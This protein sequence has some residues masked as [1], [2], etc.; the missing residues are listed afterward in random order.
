MFAGAFFVGCNINYDQISL[1]ASKQVVNLEVGETVDV[2]VTIE[3]YQAGFSNKV[4]LNPMAEGQTSIFTVLDPV[5][6]HENEFRLTIKGV[7]G[8]QGQLE[9]VTLEAEKRCVIDVSVSQNSSSMSFNSSLLYVSNKTTFVPDESLFVFDPHTTNTEVSYYFI[10]PGQDIN[11]ASANLQILDLE[12]NKATFVDGTG[13]SVTRNILQFDEVSLSEGVEASLLFENRGEVSEVDILGQFDMLAVYVPSLEQEKIINCVSTVSVFPNLD[14]KVTGGYVQSNGLVE[15]FKEITE[16]IKIVPNN[17]DLIEYML[18]VEM[19]DLE[20]A[21]DEKVKFSSIKTNVVQSNDYIAVNFDHNYSTDYD[22]GKNVRYIKITQNS[23][24]K[25]ETK[26]T[27]SL[28]YENAQKVEDESINVE[29]SYDIVTEIAPTTLQVNGTSEPEKLKL[30]NFY[31]SPEFGWRD[32]YIDVLSNFNTSPTFEGIY[33]EFDSNYLDLMYNGITIQSGQSRL[34]TDLSSPFQVRGKKGT[35]QVEETLLTIHLKSDILQSK[36][37]GIDGELT[38]DIPCQIIE[39]AKELRFAENFDGKTYFYLDYGSE[40]IGFSSQIY[41]DNEFQ[42]VNVKCISENDG[43]AIT[44]ADKPSISNENGRYYLNLSVTPLTTGI[45]TYILTLDNG[46]SQTVAFNVIK[47]LNLTSIPFYLTDEGNQNV[48]EVSYSKDGDA[49]F[50]NVMNI[51]ILNSSTKNY[52]EYGSTATF[53]IVANV[54][55]DGV[56]FEPNDSLNISVARSGNVYKITTKANGQTKI[57]FTLT[58][59]VVDELFERQSKSYELYVNASSYSLVDEFYFMN[60][61]SQALSNVVYYTNSGNIDKTDTEVQLTPIVNHESSNNFY[62]FQFNEEMAKYFFENKDFL[63]P[64]DEDDPLEEDFRFSVTSGNFNNFVTKNLVKMGYKDKDDSGETFGP[65]AIYFYALNDAGGLKAQTETVASITKT[66]V[67]SI[68]GKNKTERLNVSLGFYNGLM[69]NA[70]DFVYVDKNELGE[71]VATY[72]VTFDNIYKIGTYGEFD[73]N[74]FKYTNKITTNHTL[75][76]NANLSQRV[77]REVLISYNA[78]ISAVAYQSVKS[79]SLASGVD[80]ID[81]SSKNL[82]SLSKTIAVYTYPLA[83]TNNKI[84]VQ[85][86]PTSSSKLAKNMLEWSGDDEE[87]ESGVYKITLSCQKFYNTYGSELVNVDELLTGRIYI[88]PSEW[89]ASYTSIS[90]SYKPIVIDVQYRNG[91]KANPYI[92][93][94]AQ[95]VLDINS[96]ETSLKSHYEI[97]TTINMSSVSNQ[98]PIGVLF[99][100]GN[101]ELVGFSGSI[102]GTTAQARISNISISNNNF[103][104]RIDK[105]SSSYTYSGLFAQINPSAVIENVAFLGKFDGLKTSKTAVEGSVLTQNAY[106]GL[107]TSVNKGRLINVGTSINTS[108][109]S[110][111]GNKMYYGA[112]A[113][114][115][116]G[117][118]SQDLTKF[119]GTGYIHKQYTEGITPDD[120]LGYYV[121]VGD[122]TIR[123]DVDG[124]VV[125]NEGDKVKYDEDGNILPDSHDYTGQ[126]TRNLA[127]YDEKLTINVSN[128]TLYAGG[129][130]GASVGVVERILPNDS[131]FKMYGYSGYS[132]Y[133]DLVVA[134]DTSSSTQNI[135]VGGAIGLATYAK[136]V[137]PVLGTSELTG[138]DKNKID[139]VNEIINGQNG[140]FGLLVGGEIDTTAAA[141]YVDYVGGIAGAADTCNLG[142]IDVLSNISRTFLRVRQYVG[143]IV[144]L[145]NFSGA[146]N[147]SN[148]VNFGKSNKIQAVDDGR[149]SFYA[150]MIIKTISATLPPEVGEVPVQGDDETAED[151]AIRLTAYE[152]AE[153]ERNIFLAV[154][155]DNERIYS[156]ISF[157]VVSYL[158]RT[159]LEISAGGVRVYPASISS[160][161]D[162]YGDYLVASQG[163]GTDALSYMINGSAFFKQET[164]KLG[165]IESDFRMTSS[166]SG[167]PDLFFMYN[168]S[169]SGYLDVNVASDSTVLPQDKVDEINFFTPSSDLYPFTFESQEISISTS[170]SSILTVDVNGNM[171]TKGVGLATI[172]LSSILN[173]MESKTIYIYIFNYFDKNIT[174]SLFFTSSNGMGGNVVDGSGIT[175][176]GNSYT[177]LHLN[178]SYYLGKH[179][180]SDGKKYQI[181]SEGILNLQNVN[182]QLNK[183]SS[184]TIESS[185]DENNTFSNLEVQKQTAIFPKVDGATEF[186]TD[187]YSL[188]PVLKVSLIDGGKT[189]SYYYMF[190]KSQIN[191]NVDYRESASAIR[192]HY[193]YHSMKTNDSFSDTVT[194][195]S[196]NPEELLFYEIYDE[197]ENLVQSRLP[198]EIGQID[199]AGWENYVNQQND[200]TEK[201]IYGDLFGLQFVRRDGTNIFDFTCKINT[202]SEK[203]KNRFAENGNING[204]YVVK[205]YSSELNIGDAVCST[206]RI[207]LDEA[208]LNYLS[209]NN[210]SDFSK[211]VPDENN[212]VVASDKIAVPSQPGLLEISLDPVEAVF[213]TLTV[214]NNIINQMEGATNATFNFVYQRINAQNKLEFVEIST[215]GDMVTGENGLGDIASDGSFV[216]TYENMI[217]FLEENKVDGVLPYLGKVYIRYILPSRNVEDG[218]KVAFDVKVTHGNQGESEALTQTIPLTVKLGSYAELVFDSKQSYGG[219]YYVANGLSYDMTL[220]YYGFGLDQISFKV[221]NS[222]ANSSEFVSILP[223]GG[224]KFRLAVNLNDLSVPYN[225]DEPGYMVKITTI[226]EKIVD[227]I[228]VKTEDVMEIY[229]MEYVMDYGYAQGVNEDIVEGMENG[230]INNAIGSPYTL[231]LDILEFMEYDKTDESV[232]RELETFVSDMT[233]NVEWTVHMQK[234]TERLEEGKQIRDPDGEYFYINSFTVTPIKIYTPSNNIYHFSVNGYYTMGGGQYKYSS[235]AVNANQLYTEFSFDVHQQST[236]D[237]PI[238]VENYEELAAMDAGE[239]YILVK[240]IILP[241][242]NYA[243]ANE[244]SEFAPIAANFASLDGNGYKIYYSGSYNFDGLNAVGLFSSV[245]ENTVL[246]NITIQVI[247]DTTFNMNVSTFNVGLLAAENAGTI[248]N[249]LVEAV[250]KCGFSVISS[251]TNTAS[252]VAGLVADNSGYVT[253]SR[254]KVNLL[255]T[256]NLAGLVAQNSGLIA[257][258]YFM[259]G[260]L[261]NDT[262]SSPTGNYTAGLVINNSGKIYT[263]YVSGTSETGKVYYDGSGNNNENSITSSNPM[264]GFVFTNT[265]SVAD[266]YSNIRMD[267]NGTFNA[268]FVYE[269]SGTVERCFSTSVQ[270]RGSFSYGFVYINS[271]TEQEGD[272]SV[273]TEGGKIVDCFVLQQKEDKVNGIPAIND[274]VVL[275]ANDENISITPLSLSQFSDMSFF[276]NFVVAE[277]RDINSVWFFND[278]SD[279]V[280]N[281]NNQQFNTG[282]LELVAPNIIASSERKLDRTEIVEDKASGATYTRYIYVFKETSPALGS[283]YNPILIDS[284]ETFEDYI[285]QENNSANY[286]YSYYR[287]IGDIAY[288][289]DTSGDYLENGRTYKTKFMGYIEGNFMSIEGQ[290]LLSSASLKYA[291]MFAEL[292][293]SS[294]S[295]AVGTVMNLNIR[296]QTVSFANTNV[297]G[298]IAGK[299]D[300]G[301]I[302]NVTL[303]AYGSDAVTVDGNN[304]VGGAVGLALG[305]FRMENVHS[306]FS[307][308]ARNQIISNDNNF[309]SSSTNYALYSFAGTIA[310]VLSGSG[311]YENSTID[312][313]VSVTG[314]KAGL[315][316]G[317]I[318]EEVTARNL[319]VYIDSGMVVNG[320]NY[321]GFVAGESKGKISGVEVV[322][323]D[324]FTFTNI[325][326]I[327]YIPTAV[328][329]Y[330]GLVSGGKLDDIKMTQSISISTSSS[331]SGIESLGGI[332]GVVS[333][334]VEMSNIT[335]KANLTGFMYVGGVAGQID[336][337]RNVVSIEK[338]DVDAG[339]VVLGTKLSRVGIGGLAGKV[340]SETA[341]SMTADIDEI[342]AEVAIAQAKVETAQKELVDAET[343]EEGETRDEEQIEKLKEALEKA[344]EE[345]ADVQAEYKSLCNHFDVEMQTQL[346]VYNTEIEVYVGAILGDNQAISAHTV[347]D[348]ISNLVTSGHG[349]YV[350]DVNQP[351]SAVVSGTIS[352]AET[353]GLAISEKS[354]IDGEVLKATNLLSARCESGCNIVYTTTIVNNAGAAPKGN[355]LFLNIFGTLTSSSQS[356]A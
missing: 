7:A 349:I 220:D 256:V 234:M 183:N 329:G 27:L 11:F 248:T 155:R 253:H 16:N 217:K 80:T 350:E 330:A 269:N 162:F 316:F 131:T 353:G 66:Y 38:L 292:G 108:S 305:D 41:A 154:G 64:V 152:E 347:S 124:F 35:E 231:K 314:G 111:N 274:N 126:T 89:G 284:A 267:V 46:I 121:L 168:F 99:K 287:V 140:V 299:V 81:F 145:D 60:G 194:V 92:L 185:E 266:C 317:L 323:N 91:S 2:V 218:A 355:K 321:A 63:I 137:V 48:T 230:A 294:I 13:K 129:L 26:L 159:K 157:E 156:D 97:R 147:A 139:G 3:G 122:Q 161:T 303:E 23:Q 93:E 150:S 9:I 219:A 22:E 112:V 125:D 144:G 104:R 133:V 59:Y 116:Y 19:N 138:T 312:A 128:S 260:S 334:R 51:D 43:V 118:I 198:V 337:G 180:T 279:D 55:T 90:S 83:A 208:E 178:P 95:D 114:V 36:A 228:P 325:R 229:I 278:N 272:T 105:G 311:I 290:T 297:V 212:M 6:L 182:Y 74:N 244:C 164:V 57:K 171:T 263:S 186:L 232:A 304:I 117:K 71:V 193:S 25:A 85:Y 250:N 192:T 146:Y 324:D 65:K 225:P 24:K 196:T 333:A 163:L 54:N 78:R 302:I 243:D 285:V 239:H 143:G 53:E 17:N 261:T 76:L 275:L 213:D 237:S 342:L 341:I 207:R 246:K 206:F 62:R 184:I 40:T 135:F 336:I 191:I 255:A 39:G 84:T 177:T 172:K 289:G 107:L 82:S 96:G 211:V 127:F 240:D 75:I 222:T 68:T 102:I 224:G 30:Y 32:L 249:C 310:G 175:V 352:V 29:L 166:E 103:T 72:N 247:A 200:T 280:A 79:I 238:P 227:N 165:N 106:V 149:N 258:S 307:A 101:Y 160:T 52:V 346:Y 148:M 339:L 73:V 335:V 277:G 273:T 223:V 170:S 187:K 257:S 69:F 268:G 31:T 87:S 115:N 283:V 50:D 235:N 226:G 259:G 77:Q 286:N 345:L 109:I 282:R 251:V 141:G 221:E 203:F 1:S 291:G 188:A 195:E 181:T 199:A 348:T 58:G 270:Q 327:P 306:D 130:V 142:A 296:P 214:S 331:S 216:L 123:V 113:G 33:F 189:Y 319:K 12:S 61:S 313:A 202:E 4:K 309:N 318:D 351:S 338:V 322:G 344:E 174:S 265:G 10:Q 276:E 47:T 301:T 204:T 14:V 34:Y 254:S 153:T 320:Y 197:K 343:V 205:L 245:S 300:G 281:F 201:G 252:Y 308:K 20:Y 44:V 28:F 94:S 264:A 315:M 356:E 288:M 233:K 70:E 134:G 242:K 5:Y 100:N 326:K 332:A 271:V 37:G 210:Y 15:E 42:G 21:N 262:K 354:Y 136:D 236:D 8:G 190:A 132:A 158:T 120:A 298:T 49:E 167:A 67:D 151:F 176:V 119:D 340:G 110:A 215:V 209:L 169:V 88:F 293:S 98:L 328:G 56:N 86:I 241:C 45:S 295:N 18:R 179:E 173:V